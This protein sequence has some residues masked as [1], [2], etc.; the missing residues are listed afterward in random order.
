MKKLESDFESNKLNKY[1]ISSN[2]RN[3]KE[4]RDTERKLSNLSDYYFQSNSQNQS[5]IEENKNDKNNKKT[6][7][8]LIE[9]FLSKSE[10][11][12]T[13]NDIKGLILLIFSV[14]LWSVT[15]LFSKHLSIV[16]PKLENLAINLFR[17]VFLTIFSLFALYQLNIPYIQEIKRSRS[18]FIQLLF[19]CFFGATANVLLFACFRYMRISSGFTIFCTYPLFVSI[20]SII[21]LKSSFCCFDIISYLCCSLAVIMISKPAFI[22]GDDALKGDN[23]DSLFGVFLAFLSAIANALG[24]VINKTIALD[25]HYLSSAVFFGVFF[26]IDSALLLPFTEYGISTISLNNFLWII[27]LSFTFFLGLCGFVIALNIGNPVKILPGSYSGIVF[28]LFYNAFIFNNTTDFLDILGSMIIILFNLL[29]S[30][31]VKF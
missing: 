12:E 30:L 2:E 1:L 28:T 9:K 23:K 20:I 22:F 25:F 8:G 4:K 24:I 6:L 10:E 19:R 14:F 29:G 16:Y 3:S 26:I 15:N 17:G 13:S 7:I 31:G 5:D 11:N 27:S 18:K 21:Y